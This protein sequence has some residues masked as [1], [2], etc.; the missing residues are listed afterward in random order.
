MDFEHNIWGMGFSR[1]DSTKAILARVQLSWCL[2]RF[3]FEMD[4]EQMRHGAL[5]VGFHEGILA[6]IQLRW[7]LGRFLFEMDFE[8]MGHGTFS[9]QFNEGIF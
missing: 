5:S 8:Q 4:F 9:V 2:A 1:L 3:L 7:C 6:R